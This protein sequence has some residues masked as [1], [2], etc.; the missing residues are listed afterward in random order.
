MPAARL[1]LRQALLP[2][3]HSPATQR[4]ALGVAHPRPLIPRTV[5][6]SAASASARV[7][8]GPL[9]EVSP[10]EEAA[11]REAEAASLGGEV[12]SP[13]GEVACP[14]V[15]VASPGVEVASP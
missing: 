9:V 11:S 2:Q 6:G 13:D 5:C 1:P 8:Q 12:A 10:C 4:Q 7:G 14:G 15:E 3:W